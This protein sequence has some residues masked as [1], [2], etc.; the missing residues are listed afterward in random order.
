MN[1]G[2]SCFSDHKSVGCLVLIEECDF[3]KKVLQVD[4]RLCYANEVSCLIVAWKSDRHQK[5][6]R[7]KNVPLALSFFDHTL[8]PVL[9]HQVPYWYSW[10]HRYL[11]SRF[12]RDRVLL[13]FYIFAFSW[14]GKYDKYLHATSWRCTI[15]RFLFIFVTY[16]ILTGKLVQRFYWSIGPKMKPIERC[17]PVKLK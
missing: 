8:L 14:I 2:P 5:T 16:F 11:T 15:F 9:R 10:F 7:E 1:Q 6:G 12:W 4:I 3:R 13:G 17:V